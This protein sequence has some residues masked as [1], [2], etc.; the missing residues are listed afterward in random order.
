MKPMRD[1]RGN[2]TKLPAIFNDI[3][4]AVP[5]ITAEDV[6]NAVGAALDAA[7]PGMAPEEA[8]ALQRAILHNIVEEYAR[9]IEVTPA[10]AADALIAATQ[11]AT[12]EDDEEGPFGA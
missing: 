8:T 3:V 1:R 9:S 11:I 4:E 6:M 2:W 10:Q 7:T 5:G 12:A